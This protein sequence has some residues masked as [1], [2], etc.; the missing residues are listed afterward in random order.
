MM[1]MYPNIENA[2]VPSIALMEALH[3]PLLSIAFQILIF[4]TFVET[5][6]ALLHSVNER[7]DSNVSE[8]GHSLPKHIRPLISFGLL[9]IAIVLGTHFG[10]VE[11]IASGYNGLTIVFI[12]VL[13]IPL[14]TTGIWRSR[15]AKLKNS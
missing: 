14:L 1:S 11:L 6:A 10:I 13:I 12:V 4:G 2:P 8:L 3:M 7:I 15:K 9:T 5:G